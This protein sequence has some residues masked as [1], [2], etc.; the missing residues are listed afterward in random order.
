MSAYT[1]SRHTSSF[2]APPQVFVHRY[3][4]IDASIRLLCIEGLSSWMTSY[5]H[6]IP[7]ILLHT[8]AHRRHTISYPEMF[9]ED[10]FLK[11]TGWLLSDKVL[12]DTI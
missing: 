11:Y 9:L 1:L 6:A 2:R 8:H 3:R 4:D 12:T 5:I 10:K 7:C